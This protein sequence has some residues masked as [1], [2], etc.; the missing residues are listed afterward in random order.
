MDPSVTVLVAERDATYRCASSALSVGNIRVQFSL[1]E[2]VLISAYGLSKFA[3]FHETMAVDGEPA[4]IDISMASPHIASY[5]MPM[6]I[7]M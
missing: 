5:W 4:N 2:N 7:T 3:D 6:Q 1:K